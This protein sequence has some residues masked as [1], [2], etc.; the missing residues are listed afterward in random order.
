MLYTDISNAKKFC[1][2]FGDKCKWSR[3]FGG[4]FIYNDKY[5]KRDNNNKI[6]G[7]A[8][9]V[10]EQ[11]VKE[12]HEYE[13][14]DDAVFAAFSRHVK[15]SGANGKLEAMIDCAKPYLGVPQN[16]FDAK[17]EL[18]N[19]QNKTMNLEPGEDGIIRSSPFNS[20]DL[21]TKIS[22]VDIVNK[23]ECPLW[24][25]FLDDIFLGKK[26]IIEFMQ[27][28]VGYCLTA[29]IKEQCLF[30]LYG[31]GR[32]GKTI[33]I[34]TITKMLGDYA[35]NCPQNALIKK[36]Y[37]GGIPNDIALLKGAR[38]VTAT[39]NNQN[40]TL[41]EALI[42]QLT[43]GDMITARFLHKEFFQFMPTFKIFIATN[44]KP[45]IRG[46]DQG[47]W[48]RIRMIPFDM[49]I[50]DKNDDK[51]LKYKLLKELPGVFVWALRGYMKWLKNGLQT[52]QP[53]FEATC[54]Y[55]DEEDDLGQFIKDYCLVD[56]EGNIPVHDF[57]KKF[58]D[59]NGYFK[60]QK[61]IAEYMQRNSIDSGRSCN[62][63]SQVRVWKG[64]RFPSIMEQ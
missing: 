54:N 63:G 13:V 30:I 60:S 55:Q 56:E 32:N 36:N 62:N 61:V 21:L 43:G 16:Y 26:E 37:I 38:F 48:R 15:A 11:L 12:V 41:D 53:I 7:Y 4:W 19:C 29:S 51:D 31:S 25:K 35:V 45:N 14:T 6:K 24:I 50:T 57:K 5:W 2:M 58:R 23:A 17:S 64:I 8:I 1:E 22:G 28:V 40:V 52:P 20:D 49:R 47:I 18:I 44:H 3:D 10:H 34:N 59:I 9:E 42:K 39:E 27:R 46:T 33:F